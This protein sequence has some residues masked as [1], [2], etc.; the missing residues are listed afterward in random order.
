M[1]KP[2]TGGTP[3]L[4]TILLL[5]LALAPLAA[6]AD[7]CGHAAERTLDID[8][9]GVSTLQF[10]AAAGELDIRAVPGL[11]R[12]EVRG[13]ACHAEEEGLAEIQLRQEPT[14]A[15]ALVRVVVL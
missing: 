15:A 4:R 9:A 5:P 13:R 11:A 8:A 10:D 2:V 6:L 3:M 1:R 12:M 7:D 14:G